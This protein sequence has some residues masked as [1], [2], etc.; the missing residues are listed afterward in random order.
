MKVGRLATFL[1]SSDTSTVLSLQGGVN[2]LATLFFVSN[3]GGGQGVCAVWD[4]TS[5]TERLFSSLAA[6]QGIAVLSSVTSEGL[7]K[8]KQNKTK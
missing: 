8:T 7:E 6:L 4:D 2:G 1:L 3:D 5:P